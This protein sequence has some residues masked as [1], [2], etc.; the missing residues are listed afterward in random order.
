MDFSTPV[1]GRSRFRFKLPCPVSFT[2]GDSS[3]EGVLVDISTGGAHI[4]AEQHGLKP[5]DRTQLQFQLE[6]KLEPIKVE[7]EV[8]R[9]TQSGFAGRFHQ[10]PSRLVFQLSK[11]V[12]GAVKRRFRARM[13][14]CPG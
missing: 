2:V 13:S 3:E 6:A 5:G 1:S 11:E 7:L 9:E 8:V 10:V 14:S 12:A 4:E